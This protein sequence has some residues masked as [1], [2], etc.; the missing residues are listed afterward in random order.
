MVPPTAQAR[1]VLWE[2]T[3]ARPGGAVPGLET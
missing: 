2:L 3:Q 1:P